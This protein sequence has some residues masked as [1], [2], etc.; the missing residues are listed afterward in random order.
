MA[1]TI[2]EDLKLCGWKF[3][4]TPIVVGHGTGGRSEDNGRLK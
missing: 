1:K 3:Q 4:M 2:I